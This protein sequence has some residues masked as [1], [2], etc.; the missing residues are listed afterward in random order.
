MAVTHRCQ[1]G[2][3]WQA[4]AHWVGDGCPVCG[5]RS[6]GQA[7]TSSAAATIPASRADLP[8]D[9]PTAAWDGGLG[10]PTS[11]PIPVAG[12]EILGELG[13]GGMGVVFRARQIKLNRIVA[14][15]MVLSGE[16]ASP[17]E[18][19]R[20]RAEAEAAAQLHHPNIVQL[21]EFGEA[22]SSDGTPLPYFALEFVEGGSLADRLTG[23]P[24]PA[25]SSAKVVEELAQAMHYAHSRGVVHRDLKPAN[26]LLA[27][28]VAT[29]RNE[30]AAL[31]PPRHFTNPKITDFGLA[32]R[33]DST[34]GQT[35]SGAI[36]GTPQYMAP[37]QAAGKS[38]RVGPATDIYALGA[39][40][41]E[42][43]TGRP[44]FQGETPLETVLQVARDAPIPPRLLNPALPRDLETITLKCLQKDAARRYTSAQDLADDLARFRDDQPITARPAGPIERTRAWVRRHPTAGSLIA[45]T[46]VAASA[47]L[48]LAYRNHLNLEAAYANEQFE[49]GRAHRRLVEV[50]ISNG[51]R[52]ADDGDVLMALPWYVEALAQDEDDPARAA[53][54][55][56]RI[57]AALAAC[58]ELETVWSH[59]SGVTDV[60]FRP[61]GAAVATACEN[62]ELSVWDPNRPD[63]P[64]R[65]FQHRA[66]IR[67]IAYS[68]DGKRILVTGG[69][70]A[71][72]WDPAG[73]G[74]PV[75]LLHPKP[76]SE[77]AW[78]RD[79]RQII[80]ACEDGI[81]RIWDIETVR[82]KEGDFGRGALAIAISGDGV[83]FATGG[84]DG[85]A[86]VWDVATGQAVS[87]PIV[88]G[89]PVKWLALGPKGEEMLTAGGR[90]ARVWNA[91]T[92]QAVS[93]E[94]PFRQ[95]LTDVA[96]SSD[97]RRV[98]MASA[99]GTAGVWDADRDDWTDDVIK[100]GSSI[101]SASFSADSKWVATA[102]DDNSARVWD[103]RFGSPRTPP[104]PHV[105]TVYRAVFSPDGKR[106][107][108]AGEDGLAKLWV[109]PSA[110]VETDLPPIRSTGPCEIVGRDGSIRIQAVADEARVFDQ[111]TGMPLSPPLKHDGR[112]TCVALSP[113]GKLAATASTN[114]TALIWN[115][116]AGSPVGPSMPHGSRVNDVVFSPD[117]QRVATGSDDNTIRIWDSTTALLLGAPLP[118]GESVRAVRYNPDGQLLL[119]AGKGPYARVWNADG[120]E[121]IALVRRTENW[122]AAVLTDTNSTR[123][124]A[125]PTDRRPLADLVAASGWLSGHRVGHNGGLIPIDG[126]VLRALG[127]RLRT[128]R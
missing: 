121:S 24:Q 61:G 80:T 29:A 95:D 28:E 115:W 66:P 114:R 69:V 89:G 14:L 75:A 39:I 60:A 93:R 117:G 92:G 104:L 40:L 2:H 59:P 1:N 32:K 62:G 34:T 79:G 10:V 122:A 113:D 83:R 33:M 25:R 27:G 12:Y 110:Q 108:T 98:F 57:A 18:L 112:I 47:V 97:G 8:F 19:A 99:D 74:S 103:A 35:Q 107:L 120:G 7:N 125:L 118:F 17:N 51:A 30:G 100:H 123:E 105:G 41:Y 45:V 72:V 127:E 53:V 84:T 46:L 26:V 67:R 71:H 11:S 86:R 23:T 50:I 21:Y 55:R 5:A 54:H 31:A 82:A 77:A 106:L 3:S 52:R 73:A 65:R 13:R 96:L 42:L 90:S 16:L 111:R 94:L 102:S 48:A 109:L 76:V 58:P 85:L 81:V 15:K 22:R 9:T 68:N 88:V 37:E 56:M 116:R 78:T 64:P 20:F 36:L 43:I 119:A 38:K 44:P 70:A 101:M 63:E 124:W 87:P 4:H 126:E 49:R 128:K 6:V 91:V